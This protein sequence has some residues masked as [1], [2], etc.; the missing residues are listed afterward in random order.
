[1]IRIGACARYLV[2][3]KG[4][5]TKASRGACFCVARPPPNIGEHRKGSMLA[6]E[7]LPCLRNGLCFSLGQFS[8]G[9]EPEHT[10]GLL[11]FP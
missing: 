6:W 7:T 11:R 4:A 10:T 8:S 9:D 5:E 1:M 3:V 2:G